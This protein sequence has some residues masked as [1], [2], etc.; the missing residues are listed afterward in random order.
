M[1]KGEVATSTRRKKAKS[2]PHTMKVSVSSLD[3]GANDELTISRALNRVS[4]TREGRESVS[5]VLSIYGGFTVEPSLQICGR[6]DPDVRPSSDFVR[7]PHTDS[8]EEE[9][10]SSRGVE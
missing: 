3:E 8:C 10:S 9:K 5:P 2:K 6:N 4:A 7:I 1:P